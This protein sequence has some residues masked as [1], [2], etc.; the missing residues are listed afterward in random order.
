MFKKLISLTWKLLRAVAFFC[1]LALLAPRLVTE[2]FAFPRLHDSESAP[3]RKVAIVFGAG[4]WRDGTPTPVLRDRISTASGLYFQGKVEKLLMSGDNRFEDYNEPE[5]MQRYAIARGIPPED[6]QPDYGG[7]RTYD[8]CY[9]AREIFG[10]KNAVLI[11]QAFH[12]PRALFTCRQL[13]VGAVGVAADSQ[14]YRG[15]R[16]YEFRETAATLVALVDV[17][18]QNPPPVLGEPIHLH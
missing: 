13:G 16:W 9:R 2:L 17:I 5:A 6:I 3:L 8:S 4:L 11:T 15:A 10:L 14:L 12:L 18:R 1:L 7:R